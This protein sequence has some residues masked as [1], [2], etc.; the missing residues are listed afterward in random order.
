MYVAITSDAITLLLIEN[1]NNV[2]LY[3]NII[4]FLSV[5]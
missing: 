1:V 3:E 4:H 2:Y 5:I